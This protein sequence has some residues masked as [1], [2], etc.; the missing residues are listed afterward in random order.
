MSRDAGFEQAIAA[1][2]LSL[3]RRGHPD[4]AALVRKHQAAGGPPAGDHQGG[5]GP[6]LRGSG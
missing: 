1:L 5:R 3:E 6:Q 2:V 4:V